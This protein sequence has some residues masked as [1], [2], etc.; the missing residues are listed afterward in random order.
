VNV[1]EIQ[2]LTLRVR[3][4]SQAVDFWNVV[5]LW[6]L[7]IAALAAI[8]VGISTRLAVVRT[9]QLGDAQDQ[10]I[11]AKDRQL[12]AELKEKDRQIAVA[13]QDAAHASER[14]G[15]A[16]EHA[17]ALQVDALKLRQQMLLQGPRANL[18][19][20]ANRQEIVYALK[21]FA[22]Q[23]IDVRHSSFTIMVN[24]SV[25][26]S[27]PVGDDALGLAN[28]LVG[29]VHDAGW[30]APL[31]PL[32]ASLQGK[33]V[34]VDI[35]SNSP[36]ETRRAAGVLVKTLLDKH[37]ETVGPF[38]FPS[39]NWHLTR[40]GNETIPPALDDSTIVLTVCSHE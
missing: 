7:A 34:E 38:L 13:G 36:N 18:L 30:K 14:A 8:V 16:S 5:M 12:Q 20:G 6:G 32:I 28:A 25:V 3:D 11:A 1:T 35:S 31:K 29:V 4:L 27:T 26:T 19:A 15:K 40:V 37:I 10:L 17:A 22:G 23:Q 33:G 24:G 9:G 21:P 2:S 39:G